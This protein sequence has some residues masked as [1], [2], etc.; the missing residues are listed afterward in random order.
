M[1]DVPETIGRCPWLALAIVLFL[2][3]GL[4]AGSFYVGFAG[5]RAL[6]RSL[7]GNAADRIS[8]ILVLSGMIISLLL[9]VMIIMVLT[10]AVV[11]SGVPLLPRPSKESGEPENIVG[12][13]SRSRSVRA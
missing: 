9:S 2:L 5:L 13:P 8:H 4:L 6:Y 12:S 1:S 11:S 10:L 7:Y 3:P